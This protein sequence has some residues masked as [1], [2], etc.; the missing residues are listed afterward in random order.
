MSLNLHQLRQQIKSS[1]LS[2]KS[3]NP[4]QPLA[5][6]AAYKQLKILGWTCQNDEVHPREHVPVFRLG[7]AA[8]RRDKQTPGAWIVDVAGGSFNAGGDLDLI[9]AK[10]M[11][12]DCET[13]EPAPVGMTPAQEIAAAMKAEYPHLDSRIDSALA[14]V[15]AGTIEFPQYQ[16]SHTIGNG[17]KPNRDCN[18]PDAM[19][20]GFRAEWGIACKHTIAQEIAYRVEREFNQVVQREIIDTLEWRQ[21]RAEQLQRIQEAGRAEYERQLAEDKA[22]IDARYAAALAPDWLN[23]RKDW[24]RMDVQGIGHR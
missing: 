16:T 7:G 19:H 12:L 20:R 17:G 2:E 15:E 14:L 9:T 24:R 6:N 11:E 23:R 1:S 10:A 4:G 13:N 8:I 3:L 21:H 22:K 5:I 18:C